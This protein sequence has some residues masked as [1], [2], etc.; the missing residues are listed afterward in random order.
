MVNYRFKCVSLNV[1]LGEDGEQ[2]LSDT[3]GQDDEEFC[4]I[5]D[6]I[7]HQ[8]LNQELYQAMNDNLSEKQQ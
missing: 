2:E 5:E 8:E 4:S 7:Y 1:P 6:S 3:L